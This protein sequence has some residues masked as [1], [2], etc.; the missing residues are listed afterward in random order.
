[1]V[2]ELIDRYEQRLDA[3]MKD[4]EAHCSSKRKKSVK[5]LP[6]SPSY[7][8]EVLIPVFTALSEILPKGIGKLKVP[9][10]KIYRP[11]KEYYRIKVGLKTVGGFLVPTGDGFSLYY[12]PLKSGLPI[13]EQVKIESVEQLKEMIVSSFQKK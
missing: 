7:L 12:A 2:L 8:E 3:Y 1:M 5:H 10:P 13:G 6:V 11:I 9:D 4:I